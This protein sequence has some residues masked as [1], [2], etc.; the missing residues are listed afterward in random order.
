MQYTR[1]VLLCFAVETL[2][3]GKLNLLQFGLKQ[4]AFHML[5]AFLVFDSKPSLYSQQKKPVSNIFMLKYT[6]GLVK[7]DHSCT[8]SWNSLNS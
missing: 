3:F 8:H 1:T 6:A 7:P 5:Y 4:I 2:V